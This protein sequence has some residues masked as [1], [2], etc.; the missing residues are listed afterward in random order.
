[1]LGT[2]L[3]YALSE[4]NFDDIFSKLMVEISAK[5]EKHG[6]ISAP[7]S[8]PVSPSPPSMQI[9]VFSSY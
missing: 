8:I 2:K 5:K 6:V 1:M 9:H 4:K 3:Y 7:T